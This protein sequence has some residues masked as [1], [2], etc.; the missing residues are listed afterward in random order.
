V[1]STAIHWMDKPRIRRFYSDLAKALRR[2]GIYLNGDVMPR[3]RGKEKL[4]EISEKIRYSRHGTLE[5]EFA[6]WQE[7]WEK[8]EREQEGLA[9]EFQE[10]R[11]RFANAQSIRGMLPLEFHTKMLEQVGFSEI[12]TV[13]QNLLDDR[14]LAAIR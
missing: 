14:V 10:R 11:K 13:W 5:V 1:S 9:P 7:W 6:P 3:G 12:D 2:G 8:V 4:G